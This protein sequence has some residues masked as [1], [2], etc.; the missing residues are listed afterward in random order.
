MEL[1]FHLINLIILIPILYVTLLKFQLGKPPKTHQ[2]LVVVLITLLLVTSLIGVIYFLVRMIADTNTSRYYIHQSNFSICA[3]FF[4]IALAN[5]IY[6]HDHLYGL[7]DK[8]ILRNGFIILITL[9]IAWAVFAYTRIYQTEGISDQSVVYDGDSVR[10]YLAI[11]ALV[12][13]GISLLIILG[14]YRKKRLPKLITGILATFPIILITLICYVIY[15]PSPS[16]AHIFPAQAVEDTINWDLQN[17]FESSSNAVSVIFDAAFAN[18][19]IYLYMAIMA[20]GVFPRAFNIN[21]PQIQYIG[22]VLL[23][24]IPTIYIVSV[25]TN[26]IPTPPQIIAIMGN[27]RLFAK[28]FYILITTTI[29]AT[30]I[31]IIVAFTNL[32]NR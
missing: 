32:V 21:Y 5:F 27:N 14:L 11:M 15:F 6:L 12:L 9:I 7:A 8:T 26:N 22:N 28:W 29:F 18:P 20:L 31:A 23:A 30:E 19:A 1:I 24:L 2:T 17:S 4:V 3:L 13:G 16:V 10:I 25:L